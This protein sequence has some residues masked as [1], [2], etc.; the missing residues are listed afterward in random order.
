MDAITEPAIRD[1]F[2]NCSKGEA[3][4]ATLPGDLE[5]LSWDGLDF[6]G[7]VDPKAPQTAYVVVPRDEGLTGIRLRRNPS[8]S[9]RARMCSLCCTVHPANGVALMVANRAGR[10]GREGNSV[11]VDVCA[12][13]RCSGY[14]RGTV[15][16]PVVSLIEET[17]TVEER[18]ERLRR[19]LEAFVLRVLR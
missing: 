14:V 2:V 18:V 16:P 15:R 11:G 1:S 7:W 13:L 10:A 17:T 19:N 8:G 4:R 6:L 5:E 3:R 9:G 12:D